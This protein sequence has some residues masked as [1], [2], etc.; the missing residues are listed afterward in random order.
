VARR[1]Y[2]K[3]YWKNRLVRWDYLKHEFGVQDY[4]EYPLR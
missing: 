2:R 4:K 3:Y 1:L